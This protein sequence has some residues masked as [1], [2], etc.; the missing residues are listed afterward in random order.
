MSDLILLANV[1]LFSAGRTA[2]GEEGAE[3]WRLAVMV[4]RLVG[5]LTAVDFPA[6][7]L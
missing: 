2:P 3:L 1:L 5:G 6:A 4:E 7:P